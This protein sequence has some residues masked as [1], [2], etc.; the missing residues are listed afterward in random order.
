[1][2][3]QLMKMD[4][5]M[6]DKDYLIGKLEGMLRLLEDERDATTKRLA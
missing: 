6:K 4:V 1:M 5:D 3:N 2:N